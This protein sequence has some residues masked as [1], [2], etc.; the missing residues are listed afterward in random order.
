M[1]TRVKETSDL[2]H[3]YQLSNFQQNKETGTLL[4]VLC[5]M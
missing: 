5:V 4:A 3:I 2:F 1:Q